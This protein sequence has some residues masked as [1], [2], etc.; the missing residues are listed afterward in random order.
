MFRGF[1]PRPYPSSSE[2]NRNNRPTDNSFGKLAMFIGLERKPTYC[3]WLEL[4][5]VEA[6]GVAKRLNLGAFWMVDGLV[7]DGILD[8][9]SLLFGCVVPLAFG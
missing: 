5:A 6:E 2:K 1:D 7:L 8:G 9:S 3:T 4:E